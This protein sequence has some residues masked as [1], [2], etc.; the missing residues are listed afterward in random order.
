MYLTEL[1]LKMFKENTYNSLQAIQK[2]LIKP[3]FN[4]LT[5]KPMEITLQWNMP[6]NVGWPSDKCACYLA[7][8]RGLTWDPPDLAP[9]VRRACSNLAFIQTPPVFMCIC[10]GT[11]TVHHSLVESLLERGLSNH[12][13]FLGVS[14]CQ[15]Q[16]CEGVEPPIP[17]GN[18]QAAGLKTHTQQGVWVAEIKRGCTMKLSFHPPF[19]RGRKLIFSD[20]SLKIHTCI[21]TNPLHPPHLGVGSHPLFPTPTPLNPSQPPKPSHLK[22]KRSI[23]TSAT[24]IAATT[25]KIK[26]KMKMKIEMSKNKKNKMKMKKKTM[27]IMMNKKKLN[28][29]HL[30]SCIFPSEEN[31][32][33]EIKRFSWEHGYVIVICCS[34]KGK[35][36]FFKCYIHVS[37]F[38]S[39]IFNSLGIMGGNKEKN[40][41]VT[42]YIFY[43]LFFFSIFFPISHTTGHK[44]QHMMEETDPQ[45]TLTPHHAKFDV[46]TCQVT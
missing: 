19:P 1:E 46:K 44:S 3:T 34:E 27:E 22:A 21:T 13:S 7:N 31:M 42:P 36:K 14:A 32:L 43:S 30:F 11:V 29:N 26:M 10:F 39:E 6:G 23:N 16:A 40:A 33:L 25:L 5:T 24:P 45:L 17:L 20:I 41:R 8:M 38:F 2:V 9:L 35:R 28:Q 12:R 15:L 4:T 18:W 37:I